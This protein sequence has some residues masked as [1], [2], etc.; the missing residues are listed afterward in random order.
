MWGSPNSLIPVC[1]FSATIY[2]AP[3]G[4]CVQQPGLDRQQSGT[5]S[6]EKG[7]GWR[8]QGLCGAGQ[9]GVTGGTP[10]SEGLSEEGSV[11][12][13]QNDRKSQPC[14]DDVEGIP[15]RGNSQHRGG[16]RRQARARLGMVVG[17][18][19]RGSGPDWRAGHG[20][21]SNG[22][23]AL[24]RNGS[25]DPKRGDGSLA[26]AVPRG[27]VVTPQVIHTFALGVPLHSSL[28]PEGITVM[29]SSSQSF[30]YLFCIT[31]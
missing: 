31:G 21:I 11:P 14:G 8:A 25:L 29:I 20:F 23:G 2:Q 4:Y 13:G 28:V 27:T 19:Q 6:E 24:D 15:G 5:D 17:K 10:D 1:I 12:S 7:Q 16:G 3:A 30:E 9:C 22:S 26:F 18:V